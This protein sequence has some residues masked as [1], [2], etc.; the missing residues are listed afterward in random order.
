VLGGLSYDTSGLL[1]SA[2]G[3]ALEYWLNNNE[4]KSGNG[5]YQDKK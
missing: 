4:T 5:K 2:K 3:F 1:T